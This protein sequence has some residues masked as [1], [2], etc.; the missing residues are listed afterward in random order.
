VKTPQKQVTKPEALYDPL[1]ALRNTLQQIND[2]TSQAFA[3]L[4]AW[5]DNSNVVYSDNLMSSATNANVRIS[6]NA[7]EQFVPFTLTYSTTAP[8]LPPAPP[9]GHYASI[10]EL[11]VQ[12]RV[13]FNLEGGFLAIHVLTKSVSYSASSVTTPAPGTSFMPC[14]NSGSVTVPTLQAGQML[15]TYYCPTTTQSSSWQVAA[16]VGV[17]WIP[18]GR[19]YYPKPGDYLKLRK[20]GEMFGLMIGTSVTN[21]GSGFGGINFAPVN[22]ISIYAG[23]ASAHSSAPSQGIG[24]ASNVYTT[25]SP[26]TI[27]SLRFGTALGIGFDLGI[28]GQIF[29]SA[30]APGLP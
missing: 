28:F 2:S 25:S 15:P 11:V 29:K 23:I 3:S 26:P 6:I 24:S 4:N 1:R 5:Y 13:H 20:Y 9:S 21:L 18:W 19:N 12:R 22:G 16:M 30:S 17:T 14:G 8:T 10:T 7:T 27:T